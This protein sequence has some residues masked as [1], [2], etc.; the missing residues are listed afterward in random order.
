MVVFQTLSDNL[1]INSIYFIYSIFIIKY[2]I[3]L[4]KKLNIIDYPTEKRKIHKIPTPLV[5]FFYFLF[6]FFL[7][8]IF[9]FIHQ[10]F[11][12]KLIL[13]ICFGLF[14]NSL[15]GLIDDISSI[16]P[17]SRLISL[18]FI[19]LISITLSNEIIINSIESV[20][21][22][23]IILLSSPF[24]IIFTVL[25]YL[26]LINS[27]NLS[28]GI[29]GLAISL[30]IIWLIL[31]S[32]YSELFIL[33]MNFFLIIN[34]V[35]LLYYNMKSKIFLGSGGINFLATYVCFIT[36]YTFNNSEI[37]KY[38]FIFLFLMI[39]GIDMLRVFSLRIAKGKNPFF[40]DQTHLHHYLLRNYSTEKTL[41]I[42]ISLIIIPI[43]I[44]LNFNNLIIPMI[45]T[46]F[47]LY[48]YLINKFSS[49]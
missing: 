9:N 26:L 21:L 14:F 23:N 16:S 35:I 47:I 4:T 13:S 37:L 41:L 10:D 36:V 40:S 43:L 12:T 5:G 8:L 49:R 3:I 2:V 7:F 20:F 33:K 28:D 11:S 15:I 25:C 44:F 22:Q 30:S 39:P 19:F 46:K 17:N 18:I 42:Y 45:I 29:N 24:S 48:L 32:L 38:E 27:L 34:L 1:I 6:S 31:I